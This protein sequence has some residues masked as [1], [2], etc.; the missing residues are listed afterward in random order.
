MQALMTKCSR[1]TIRRNRKMVDLFLE[2][3]GKLEYLVIGWHDLERHG[4]ILALRSGIPI[5]ST[6]AKRAATLALRHDTSSLVFF[7]LWRE[8]GQAVRSLLIGNYE[9]VYRSLRWI[10]EASV[11]WA[12][13]QLD[14]QSAPEQFKWYYGQRGKL[15]ES[16]YD[17]MFHELFTIGSARFEER[18]LFREKF[19]RLTAGEILNGLKFAGSNH[20]TGVEPSVVKKSLR[21]IYSNLS[22]YS[23]LTLATVHEIH[24]EFLHGDFAFYQDYSYD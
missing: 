20:P 11:F 3:C 23:H 21:E 2:I 22:E 6:K 18:L 14:G 15:N 9:S 17:R 7:D 10:V 13:M 5:T 24:Y 4:R 16:E 19:R 1:T 8:L 12:D